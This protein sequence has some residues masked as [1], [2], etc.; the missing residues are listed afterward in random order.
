MSEFPGMMIALADLSKTSMTDVGAVCLT[1]LII[2][3][4][5]GPRLWKEFRAGRLE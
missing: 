2:F 3:A 5:V 4:A 1:S